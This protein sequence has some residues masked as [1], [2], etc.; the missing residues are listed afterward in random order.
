MT[1]KL[2]GF[3]THDTDPRPFRIIDNETLE[4]REFGGGLHA[5]VAQRDHGWETLGR[6]A[7]ALG[8]DTLR[9]WEAAEIGPDQLVAQ[10]GRLRAAA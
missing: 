10:A 5:L 3:W 4:V 8:A 9:R 6:I 7:E 1:W 2:Q